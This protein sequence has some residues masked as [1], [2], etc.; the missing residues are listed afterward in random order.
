MPLD[1]FIVDTQSPPVLGLKAC[2]DLDMIKLVLSVSSPE[3]DA[4]SVVDEF[5][6]V[7]TGIGLFPGECNIHLDPSATPVIHPPRRVPFALRD[8]L[9]EELDS[10][11]DQGIIKKVT[12]PTDWVNALCVVEKPKTGKLRVCLDPRDLN[13]A[14]KCPHYPLPTLEDITPKLAGARYFSVM[15]TRSGYWAVKLSE[16]SSYLITFN[17]IFGR[18]R[19]C[20]LPFGIVSAQDVF[21]Q[22]IDEIYEG[23]PGVVAIVDDNLVYGKTKEEHDHN[24]RT[25]LERS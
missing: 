10:M 13:K 9:R 18:Y 12:E 25:M 6:D 5:A 22:K 1:F 2:I 20:R 15:D 19:F 14:I 16:K 8:R 21:Q 4:E 17:T 11:E 7:F 3:R 24:L 23:L